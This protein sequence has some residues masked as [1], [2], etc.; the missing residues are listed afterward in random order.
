VDEF[1]FQKLTDQV[2]EDPGH[3][4]TLQHQVELINILRDCEAL[5]GQIP[6]KLVEF[7]V[8][9]LMRVRIAH[10]DVIRVAGDMF[11]LLGKQ[12]RLLD[13]QLLLEDLRL[14]DAGSLRLLRGVG[15]GLGHPMLCALPS[16]LG[17]GRALD[18]VG[19]LLRP[20]GRRLHFHFSSLV[21]DHADIRR[22][23]HRHLCGRDRL[24]SYFVLLLHILLTHLIK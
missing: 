23:R 1:L 20:V 10:A 22:Y 18:R 3:S 19:S 21:N 9:L 5:L 2:R 14:V 6:G 15:T 12:V 13:Y 16:T 17:S 4:P 8:G 24:L 7:L 11:Q